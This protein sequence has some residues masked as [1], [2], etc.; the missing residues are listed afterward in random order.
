MAPGVSLYLANPL[1]QQDMVSTVAWMTSKGVKIINVSLGFSYEG[2]GDG[3]SP[4]NTMYTVIDQAVKGGALWVNAAGNSGQDGWVGAWQDANANGLLDFAPGDEGDAI[5]LKAGDNILATL[6]WNDPWGHA[7]DDYD[8]LLFGP[9]GST[10]LASSEDKQSGSQDPVETLSFTAQSAGTY[11]LAIR[12]SDGNAVSRLQL[13]V[14]TEQDAPLQYQ[15]ADDTLSTPAD[16]A[17]PGMVTVGAVDFRTPDQVETFSARGPTVDNRIKP[18]FVAADC[19][20]TASVN[21]FCGT[22]QAAPYASGAAALV[23]NANPKLTPSQLADFLR[24]HTVPLGAP[25]PNNISGSGRLALGPPPQPPTPTSLNFARAPLVGEAATPFLRQPVVQILDQ[26][27]ETITVGPGATAAVVLQVGANPGSATL[28]CDGGLS[29]VAVA[30]VATFSGCS[31]STPGTAYTLT[32]SVSG[33]PP[34][35]TGPFDIFLAGQGPP[36]PS[37]TISSNVTSVAYGAAIKLTATIGV[38]PAGPTGGGRQVTLQSS[39]DGTTWLPIAQVTTGAGGAGTASYKPAANLR[40]RATFDGAADLNPATSS[41]LRVTVREVVTLRPT[42]GSKIKS[43]SRTKSTLF[44][45]TVRPLASG[46]LAGAVTFEL[47]RLVGTRWIVVTTRVVPA[48]ALGNARIG[49][50]FGSPGTWSLRVKAASTALNANSDWSAR[51]R[52]KVT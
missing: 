20:A 4:P 12:R 16:S 44:T 34:A 31:L 33:V 32:A 51:E 15:T 39:T 35:T 6:R 2:P 22:S 49:L 47:S 43:I 9:G 52:Y 21:P 37:L 14:L 30:G 24:S 42:N 45:A 8:L 23:M 48:D 11:R 3:T 18:D 27:G 5:G 26:N 38:Q 50:R 7:A 13:L 28:T 40:F 41:G 36:T 46:V 19:A 25:V 29:V 1:S 17:N 10:A